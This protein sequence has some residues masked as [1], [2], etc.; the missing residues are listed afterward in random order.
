MTEAKSLTSGRPNAWKRSLSVRAAGAAGLAIAALLVSSAAQPQAKQIGSGSAGA[1]SRNAASTKAVKASAIPASPVAPPARKPVAVTVRPNSEVK[2][3]SFTLGEIADIAGDDKALAAQLAA[4]EV[5]ASP[6]PGLSRIINPGDVTVR[7]RQ[8]HLDGGQVEVTLPPGM[9]ITRLGHDIA[10]DEISRAALESAKDAIKDQ[11]D[12]TLEVLSGA[13]KLMVPSG[14]SQIIAGAWR[15]SP[16]VGTL[17]VPV[18]IVVDGKPIQTVDV[19]LRIRRKIRALVALHDI[20]LHDAIGPQDVALTLVDVTAGS[21]TPVTAIDEIGGKRSTRRIGANT[22]LTSEMLEKAP[23]INA[24]DSITIEF[25]YGGLRVTASGIARQTGAEGDTI[26][27]FA[28]D[29][30]RELDGVV[31]DKHTVRIDDGGTR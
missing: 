12:A 2:D 8:H 15:G 22:T 14:K 30:K 16:Q 28:S 4:I 10:T 31:I 20:S 18:S 19:T 7:L 29:T 27:V 3:A 5:G 9:R 17:T 13:A 11:P 21:G 1:K 23:L 24:N 25:V 6:L 26:H